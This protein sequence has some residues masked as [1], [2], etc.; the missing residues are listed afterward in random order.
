MNSAPYSYEVTNIINSIANPS[1][2][3]VTN[4]ETARFFRR[5]LLQKAMSVFKWEFPPT[6][7]EDYFLYS[8]YLLG[9][10][11][12][13]E[14]DKFGVICQGGQ[15]FGLD[16]FYQPT[17]YHI[18]NPLLRGLVKPRINKECTVFKLAKDWRGIGDIVAF[19]ADYMALAAQSLGVNLINSKLSYIFAA[20][21]KAFAES[22]KKVFDKVASGE[23]SVVA[24][25]KLFNPDGTL[26]MSL[27]LQNVG[28]SFIADKLLDTWT[29][30]ENKFAT[31]IGI[32]NANTDKKERLVVDEVNANNVETASLCDM[33]LASWQDTIKRT[34]EMF[35][36]AKPLSVD[37]RFKP[38][39]KED[40]KNGDAG[41]NVNS[42][43]V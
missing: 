31:A 18:A 5:Y 33:W 30:L 41:E 28:Q 14:T 23:P 19:Y 40:C 24:D 16:V 12:V 22:V 38:V 6:W 25:T 37:W 4:T 21:N 42:G 39:V 2:V 17:N 35:P 36:D 10:I 11:S 32:P 1:G 29:T 27:L 43:S 13:I 9:H 8:L 34:A 26:K 20:D 3:V 15:P 7:N